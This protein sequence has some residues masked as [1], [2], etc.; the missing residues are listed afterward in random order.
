MMVEE[1]DRLD[2]RPCPICGNTGIQTKMTVMTK[3][4]I[5]NN[6]IR[7]YAFCPACLHRGLSAIGR[8]TEDEGKKSAL[9]LWNNV[10]K[11]K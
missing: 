1:G 4:E 8:M 2:I 10:R 7:V 6:Q 3:F 5:G 9:E 11:D